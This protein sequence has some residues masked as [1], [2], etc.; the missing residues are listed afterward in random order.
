MRFVG[1]TELAAFLRTHPE[2][3][4]RLQ[5]WVAEIRYRNWTN[6]EALSADFQHVD[7][8]RLPLT[9]FRLGRPPIHI[10]TLIDFRTK[11]VLLLAIQQPYL[12]FAPIQQ[13]GMKT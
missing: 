6:T 4:D 12:Q 8:S 3:A 10:E 7:A 13:Q 1:Q 9:V 11:V 2:E 5:A